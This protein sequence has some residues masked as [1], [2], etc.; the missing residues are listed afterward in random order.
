MPGVGEKMLTQRLREMEANGLVVR[1]DHE[2]TT[3]AARLRRS[4]PCARR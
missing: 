3:L 1:H 4:G 2:T